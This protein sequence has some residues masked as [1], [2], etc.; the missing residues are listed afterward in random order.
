MLVAM[1]E[2]KAVRR[3][4]LHKLKELEAKQSE[5]K[6]PSLEEKVNATLA[7]MQFCVNN[8]NLPESGKLK[9]AGDVLKSYGL[10]TKALPSYGIDAP[11]PSVVTSGSSVPTMSLTTILKPYPMSAKAANQILMAHGLVEER[12]RPSTVSGTKTFK[13]LTAKGLQYGKNITSPSNPREVQIHW[14]ADQVDE[15]LKLL[16]VK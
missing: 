6:A 13:A 2:S 8:L 5:P 11:T 14:Y 9:I 15:L 7:V 1:R 12:S 16:C 3:S 10:E 4:V